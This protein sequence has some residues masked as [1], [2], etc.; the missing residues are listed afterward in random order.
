MALLLLL[1]S[2]LPAG[3]CFADFS[4]E[5][6]DLDDLG[7]LDSSAIQPY[8]FD[9]VMAWSNVL[10]DSNNAQVSIYG[11]AHL[12]G[13]WMWKNVSVN[14]NTSVNTRSNLYALETKIQIRL[15]NHS[16]QWQR[17][18][19]LT[20]RLHTSKGSDYV[21]YALDYN[22][23]GWACASVSRPSGLANQ[24]HQW[25]F[26]PESNYIDVAPGQTI[27]FD[28][29]IW[30]GCVDGP[31]GCVDGFEMTSFACAPIDVKDNEQG[32]TAGG[33][34]QIIDNIQNQYDTN[35]GQQDA[36][37]GDVNTAIS[38][39]ENIG[40]FSFL[41]DF[42]KQFVGVFS[43]GDDST[44]LTLPGFSIT[45]DGEQ[46]TVWEAHTFDFATM[47]GPFAVLLAALR[48]G[49]SVVVIGALISYLFGL[50]EHIFAGGEQY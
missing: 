28:G 31:S 40:L 35:S 39:I 25:T 5:I 19:S 13:G 12:L 36:I 24:V 38:G 27:I 17:F 1:V 34:Q 11:R 16:E 3:F 9:R 14:N 45:V 49:T 43:S 26:I 30:Y 44:A 23:D 41:I 20:F 22:L 48:L 4:D 10:Q 29:S 32:A 42:S 15:I 2:G 6:P 18:S 46:L 50:Y 7:D 47:E 8:S 33:Q 37:T 21:F